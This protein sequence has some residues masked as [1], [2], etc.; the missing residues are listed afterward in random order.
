MTFGRDEH[1][2][3]ADRDLA[4]PDV[5]LEL[6]RRQAALAVRVGQRRQARLADQVGLGRADGRHVHLVA[7]DDGDRDAD[8]AVAVGRL[9]AEPVRLVGEPLVGG[10]DRLLEADPDA[11]RLVV[12]VLVPDRLGG[13]AGRLAARGAS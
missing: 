5:R 10:R 7:A 4:A 8:R 9:E 2:R 13:E 1:E 11:G 3:V 6:A 12:V